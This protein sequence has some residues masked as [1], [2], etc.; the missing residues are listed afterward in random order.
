MY[1]YIETR[2]FVQ[3][4]V[5]A[6][7]MVYARFYMQCAGTILPTTDIHLSMCGM[8]HKKKDKKAQLRTHALTQLTRHVQLSDKREKPKFIGFSWRAHGQMR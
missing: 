3:A 2:I 8:I 1:V 7:L 5:L 6:Y 4:Y